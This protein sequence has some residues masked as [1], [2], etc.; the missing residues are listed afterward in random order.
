MSVYVKRDEGG[1]V[2]E[3]HPMPPTLDPDELA[4][5]YDELDWN[6][7]EV[8]RFYDPAYSLKTVAQKRF[9]NDV[10]LRIIVE[11]IRVGRGITKQEAFD[12]LNAIADRILPE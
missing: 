5:G 9:K 7:P 2:V 10:L 6:A 11:W 1:A 3:V 12:E 8:C 4:A